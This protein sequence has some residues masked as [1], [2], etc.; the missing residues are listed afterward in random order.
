MKTDETGER[1][2]GADLSHG[3]RDHSDLDFDGDGFRRRHGSMIPG[4]P[5]VNLRLHLTPKLQARFAF[6]KNI[7]RPTFAQL[8]PE[9]LA[10]AHVR[11]L[12]RDP[13]YRQRRR[14]ITPTPTP[15]LG[16]G[17]V[18]GNP[19]PQ[20][21][22]RH[23]VRRSAR[24]VFSAHRLRLCHGVRQAAERPDRLPA[25]RPDGDHSGRRRRPVQRQ[26]R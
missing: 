26:R 19:E 3:G 10:V 22:T 14:R 1:L 7:Y 12:E 25:I 4:F 5:S 11:W 2:P 16:T 24:M 13:E 6:S 23:I 8:N 17:T 20:A 21:R 9:L 15:I 18:S